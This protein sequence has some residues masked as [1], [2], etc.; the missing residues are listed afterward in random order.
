[1]SSSRRHFLK[2]T[3]AVGLAAQTLAAQAGKKISANDK[4]RV[5][6]IGAGSQGSGDA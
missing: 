6:L 5:A 4:I 3:A 2:S 1:M